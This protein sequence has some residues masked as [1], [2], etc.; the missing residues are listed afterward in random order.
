MPWLNQTLLIVHVL[1]AFYWFGVT[2]TLASRIR[3]A[4]AGNAVNTPNV[5]KGLAARSIV[6]DLCGLVVLGTGLGL[7]FSVYHGFAGLHPRFH[8]GLSVAMVWFAVG[9]FM[10]RPKL[11]A[12]AQAV[13]GG[14][15]GPDANPLRKRIAMLV[16]IQHL[17]F[18]IVLVTMLW[19]L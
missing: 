17:L 15:V 7:V 12:L 3:E 4:L 8:I 5:I 6:T 1:A 19:R 14:A 9:A 2:A 10:V 13:R 18:V 11:T 16:G